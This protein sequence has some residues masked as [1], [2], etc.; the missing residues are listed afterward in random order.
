MCVNF[1]G[2]LGGRFNA[3]V[4]GDA[5]SGYDR[6]QA[7]VVYC[8]DVNPLFNET[9]RLTIRFLAHVTLLYRVICR[10]ITAGG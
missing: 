7:L 1:V 3:V 8:L 2:A 6:P 5:L 4:G 9:Q 10:D